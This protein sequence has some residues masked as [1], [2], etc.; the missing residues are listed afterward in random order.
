MS[1]LL[2]NEQKAV[3][4]IERI[5]LS[6]AYQLHSKLGSHIENRATKR[7]SART[8]FDYTHTGIEV[9][10]P[11]ELT[12]LHILRIGITIC[13]DSNTPSKA[14]ERNLLRVQRRRQE[15]AQRINQTI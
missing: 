7:N 12:L 14:R 5:G 9:A 8:Y 15:R 11:R 13:D 3:E 2:P 1:E 4:L 10:H 6:R